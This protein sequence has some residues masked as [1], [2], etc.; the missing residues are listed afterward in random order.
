M[1]WTAV[2]SFL[3]RGGLLTGVLTSQGSCDNGQQIGGWKQEFILSHF[4]RV[5][6]RNQEWAE[7]GLWRSGPAFSSFW[8]LQDSHP[9]GGSFHVFLAW[10][11]FLNYYSLFI[12]R[13]GPRP[14]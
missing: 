14:R 5:P 6:T 7:L 4:R 13:Q 9:S 10:H 12:L 11:I 8:W 3:P 1:G 2:K